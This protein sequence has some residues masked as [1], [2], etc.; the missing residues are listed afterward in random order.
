MSYMNAGSGA[1]VAALPG[2][3]KAG[4]IRRTYG[5]LAVA[6]AAFALIEYQLI[7]MGF[8]L[9]KQLFSCH[10]SQWQHCMRMVYYKMQH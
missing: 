7:S 4:F 9:L 10:L 8:G 6:I 3:E 5:H 2:E 1:V